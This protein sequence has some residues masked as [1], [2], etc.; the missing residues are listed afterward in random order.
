[1]HHP[2][3][4][5]TPVDGSTRTPT[6]LRRS[7]FTLIELLV[8]IAIIA[9]LIGIL[10]PGLK[11]ARDT[12]RS[13][14]CKINLKQITIAASIYARDY[15][16][17]I[18]TASNWAD[19]NPSPYTFEPGL[20]FEYVQYADFV[21]E[22]PTNKRANSNGAGAGRNGFGWSRDLNF[23]YTMLDEVQGADIGRQ[24]FAA[25]VRPNDPTPINLPPSFVSH[26]TMFPGLPLFIEESTPIYNE[27]YVDGWFGNMDQV[28]ARHTKGGFIGYV[29]GQV[30]LFK[31]PAGPNENTRE[32]Q[33]FEANDIYVSTKQQANSWWKISDRGQPYGWINNPRF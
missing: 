22:C 33:D 20:L 10:L 12:A 23:D 30:D 9:V 18:W 6:R 17:R 29:D 28:T 31:P 1:M 24:F 4:A 14:K 8:V 2:I 32:A 3:Q 21:V 15:K 5:G 19:A 13:L 25:Y 27:F 7:A 26:L 16:D 11:N